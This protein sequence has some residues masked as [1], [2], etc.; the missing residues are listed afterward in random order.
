MPEMDGLEATAAIRQRERSTGG[1]ILIIAMTAYDLKGDEERCLLSGHGCLHFKTHADDRTVSNDR[2]RALQ[3]CQGH[4]FHPCRKPESIT[5]VAD[6]EVANHRSKQTPASEEGLRDIRH[7]GE[8]LSWAVGKLDRGCKKGHRGTYQTH[9]D[10]SRMTPAA[11]LATSHLRHTQAS[12]LSI[13][14]RPGPRR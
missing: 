11:A 4:S 3:D 9:F 10:N 6:P 12:P 5:G 8:R 1:P 13:C 7:K 2:E 14:S